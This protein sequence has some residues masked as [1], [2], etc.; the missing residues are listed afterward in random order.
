Y[1]SQGLESILGAL[2]IEGSYDKQ[3]T[4]TI[5]TTPSVGALVL[6]VI[7]RAIKT[8]Y[9]QLLLRNPPISDAE[10]QLSQFQTDLII[11]NMFCTNR[12]VQHHVLFTDNMVLICREGNPL[13]S[14]E[15]DRET[16]D[17]AAHVLLLP[18]E[19]NFSGLRQRVQEMFPD[20]QINFTSYNILTIAA[21][22]ANSDML[23]II[24][25]RFY[26]LFS[27]CWPLEKLPFPSL[28][29]EQI[30]FSIHYNKFSLRDPILHGVIDVIRNAF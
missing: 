11:D 25:S 8:H 26:N 1:I 5:A 7:Y 29:E 30:D 23:A 15:D 24:P 2:D 6:P 20:R 21:L 28:N 4:I 10:N 27:R 14:L 13:L 12:T 3:R 17:N 16:I 18:E 9:P 19:Q 22:V